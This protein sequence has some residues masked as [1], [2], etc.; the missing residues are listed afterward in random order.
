L[1]RPPYYFNLILGNIACAQADMLN[2]GLMIKELPHD[3]Y[4]SVGAIGEHQLT[5]NTASIVFGGGVRIGLEDNL[6]FDGERRKLATNIELVKRIVGIA[7]MLDRVPYTAM[8]AR[9]VLGLT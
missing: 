1:I 5:M 6:Y 4:W 8:E 7:K 2:L 3:S 9:Q